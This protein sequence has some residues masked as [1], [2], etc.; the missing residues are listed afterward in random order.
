M[1]EFSLVKLPQSPGVYFFKNKENEIIYIGKAAVL[2]KR[3]K[4]YFGK[5]TSM[6]D[7]TKLLI[8]EIESLDYI[9]LASEAEA[10]FLES[11]LIKRYRPKYNF[12]LK[13]EKNFIY[14]RI[15][16]LDQF[17]IVSFVRRPI[18]DQAKY[19]GP[20]VSAYLIRKTMHK[21]RK[22]FPYVTHKTLPKRGCLQYQ[23]G[24]CP[25]P[26]EKAIS[27]LEYKKILNKLIWYLKGDQAKI[28]RALEKQMQS[29]ASKKNYEAA[30]QYRDQLR[31][32]KGLS[33][34]II[35]GDQETFDLNKDQALV[36]LKKL[37]KLSK[38]PRRIEAYDISN[39]A[40][41]NAVAS[42]IVFTNGISNR[43]EYRR[44]KTKTKGPNDFAMFREVLKRRLTKQNNPKPDLILID[45]G[46]GQIGSA[47]N[48]VHKAGGN[49]P[50]IG[51]A[52]REEKIIV[53]LNSGKPL[54]FQIIKLPKTSSVLKLL[55]RIRDE[56]HRFA[57]TYHILT[58]SK[59]Q[60]SSILDN[61]YGLGPVHKRRLLNAF[62]SVAKIRVAST[63]ELTK[64]I[65]SQKAQELKQILD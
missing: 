44:F 1:L 25:G 39:F 62:G 20:Y 37:L 60:L 46:K 36:E 10:L 23:I 27:S 52:K 50:I 48:A 63:Q 3:V 32:L 35:F 21:L 33:R 7:K 42:M 9:E 15:N 51:L 45:G 14:I 40:G 19:F 58:R 31:G 54:N 16:M 11:E 41:T 24:L 49:I 26:E 13:D 38:F 64:I 53:P 18:D 34:Q 2:K 6:D 12:E 56:A 47:I 59:N 55:Q 29:A 28:V 61:I 8:Q 65:G 5:T 4:S 57:I 30:A 22:I 17:P 43:D